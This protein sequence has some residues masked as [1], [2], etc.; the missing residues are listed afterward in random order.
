MKPFDKKKRSVF[1]GLHILPFAIMAVLLV[2]TVAC[3]EKDKTKKIIVPEDS[4]ERPIMEFAGWFAEKASNNE[5][6]SLK[7]IYT[8]VSLADSVSLNLDSIDIEKTDSPDIYIVKFSK[9]QSIKVVTD[10]DG[11]I[12]VIESHG[13]FAY[14][15]VREQLARLGGMWDENLND[16]DMAQRM[17]DDGYFDFVTEK[18][19]STASNVIGV[20]SVSAVGNGA[21]A[22]QIVNKT[23]RQIWGSDYVVKIRQTHY[24][25]ENP[26]SVNYTF[27]DGKDIAPKGSVTFNLTQADAG[28]EVV[29]GINFVLTNKEQVERFVHLTGNE[30]REYLASK[31][32]PST[33]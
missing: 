19:N 25:S 15:E 20:G 6:D 10:A 30:Y 9:N 16:V 29:D 17:K 4:P 14:P 3:Q 22:Q 2:M 7:D 21:L 18:V 24:R 1:R 12:R 11:K 27:L 32:K 5:L 23:D 33:E 8:D 31:D 13:V 28:D 26:D